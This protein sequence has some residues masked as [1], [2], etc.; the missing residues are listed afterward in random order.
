MIRGHE[1]GGIPRNRTKEDLARVDSTQSLC[2]GFRTSLA[3]PE[4]NMAWL[5]EAWQIAKD[6]S[7]PEDFHQ[8]VSHI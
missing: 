5:V 1:K 3:Q 2:R 4:A 7:K 6:D 8:Q